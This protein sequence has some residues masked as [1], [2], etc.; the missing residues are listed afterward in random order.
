MQQDRVGMRQD[1]SHSMSR[2]LVLTSIKSL[3]FYSTQL[4]SLAMSAQPISIIGAGIGGLTLGRALLKHGIPAVLYDRKPSTP[5]YS[6]GITLHPYSYRPLLDILDMDEST[7]RRT[8]AVDGPVGGNG[9]INPKSVIRSED[10]STSS[11]RAHRERLEHLL[12]EGLDVRWNQELEEI[13]ESSAGMV[14]RMRTGEKINSDCIVGVDG[15]HSSVRKSLSPN[16][17]LKTL[18]VVAFNGKR[19]VTRAVFDK[20]YAPFMQSSNLVEMKRE[21]IVLQVQVSDQQDH[22]VSVGWVYSRPAQGQTDA[23]HKPN[24]PLSGATD[25]PEEFF[26]EITALHD[27]EQPFK[28]VFDVEKL[29]E[30][31]ILHWLMRTVLMSMQELTQFAKKGIF[32]IGDAVH[33]QPIIGGQGANAAIKDGVELANCIARSGSVGLS[34]FYSAQYPSWKHGVEDSEN[35]IVEIHR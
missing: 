12:R 18:P 29:K 13:Q 22:M 5:R 1:I 21:G 30:E 35:I 10:I 8:V 33:A 32:F 6:Y 24:R 11:F 7:F 2:A 26:Q 27:L 14:L 19:R 23:L 16:T 3:R 9:K 20:I 17:L 15:P 28:E 31:R 25:I 4:Q 34:D